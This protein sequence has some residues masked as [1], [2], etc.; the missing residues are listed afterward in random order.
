MSIFIGFTSIRVG[1]AELMMENLKVNRLTD[2][3][4][5]KNR[6]ILLCFLMM[7]L[8]ISKIVLWNVKEIVNV[9]YSVSFLKG[10]NVGKTRNYLFFFTYFD[11]VLKIFVRFLML[12]SE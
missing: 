9:S 1:C 8:K 7:L 11:W 3:S 10:I 5:K 4:Q 12:M 6:L 2:F